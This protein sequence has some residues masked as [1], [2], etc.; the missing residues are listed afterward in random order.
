MCG[1]TA[2][3]DEKNERVEGWQLV[4][5]FYVQKS[6]EKSTHFFKMNSSSF[7]Y[8]DQLNKMLVLKFSR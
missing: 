2:N 4:K 3:A 5:I 6:K 8:G 1:Q 7:K